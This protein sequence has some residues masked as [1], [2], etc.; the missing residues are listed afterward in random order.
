MPSNAVF[1]GPE[2]CLHIACHQVRYLFDVTVG[3]NKGI[4]YS[5]I[6]IP[7]VFTFFVKIS[8]IFRISLVV[9]QDKISLQL[10]ASGLIGSKR[11][12]SRFFPIYSPLCKL[13]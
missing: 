13:D 8:L 12:F 7:Y 11:N 1:Q 4:F 5:K 3:F 2:V 10:M 6:L 9:K